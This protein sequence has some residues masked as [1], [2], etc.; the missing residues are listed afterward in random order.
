[1]RAIPIA[2]AF[3]VLLVAGASALKAQD[4]LPPPSFPFAKITVKGRI[5]HPDAVSGDGS[6]RLDVELTLSPKSD[7]ILPTDENVLIEIEPVPPLTGIPEP[8]CNIVSV[9]KGCL[10]PKGAGYVLQEPK[11]CGFQWFL[12]FEDGK[13]LDLTPHV[14]RARLQLEESFG[15]WVLRLALDVTG[16][17]AAAYPSPPCNL[18]ATVGNDSGGTVLS[19][20]VLFASPE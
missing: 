1:M 3:G 6:V 18:V 19:S 11:A 14:S 15:K 16:L 7:G 20:R 13:T 12:L 2:G 5:D 17:G 9:P 8:P 10:V 4:P